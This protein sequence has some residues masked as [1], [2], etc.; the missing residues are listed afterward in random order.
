MIIVAIVIVNI[1]VKNTLIDA[2]INHLP[3][4]AVAQVRRQAVTLDIVHKYNFKKLYGL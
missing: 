3:A 4:I 2:V 1:L